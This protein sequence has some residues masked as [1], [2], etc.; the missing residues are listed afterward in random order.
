MAQQVSITIQAT[1]DRESFIA[2]AK[3]TPVEAAN[4]LAPEMRAFENWMMRRNMDPLTSIES[5]II[6]EYLGY[7]MTT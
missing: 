2:K 7:K 5:Q 6:R 3:S 1:L 4:S